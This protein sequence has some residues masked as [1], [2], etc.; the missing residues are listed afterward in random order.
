MT[1]EHGT[2][3]CEGMY[4]K[5]IDSDSPCGDLNSP[6]VRERHVVHVSPAKGNSRQP[7][8]L[9]TA[10]LTGLCL[11][12]LLVLVVMSS[13]RRS[14]SEV[15]SSLSQN[16]SASA[17][18]QRQ[19]LLVNVTNLTEQ[20]KRLEKEKRQLEM[21]RNALQE[22]VKVQ[23]AT[24]SPALETTVPPPATPLPSSPSGCPADWLRFAD[25]CYY[26]STTTLDWK[27]SQKFCVRRGG[28]LA[29]IH[30]AEEQTFIW[31]KL[32]RGHWN[33]YW[34]GITDEKLEGTWHWVD[35][36]ELVDNFW[37]EGEPNNHIDEDCG[38][39]VKTQVRSRV[40]TKSWYDAPCEMP[41][42]FVCEM[43][44]PP[45]GA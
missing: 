37:E 7:Y 41:C 25:S 10:C 8:K 33:A 16:S 36:T 3:F 26:I 9:A 1:A 11:V 43:E 28:H 34:F 12:L 22:R 6:D 14:V 2:T 45:A 39:I 13:Q 30:T 42:L 24:C 38:Y 4:S 27:S 31:N 17:Q 19:T 23:E 29:I 21:E 18:T 44:K 40:P 15:T 35:G 20:I 5:L 32:V